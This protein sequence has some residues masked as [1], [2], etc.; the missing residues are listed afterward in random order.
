MG[1]RRNPGRNV[2][3][4]LL[5]DK[6]LGL[7]SN[8]ALQRVKRHYRA[9]KA[10][11]TGSLDPLATGLLPCCLGDSTKFSAFLLDADKRY[12]VRVR[13]GVTTTTADAEGEVVETRPVEGV[14]EERLREVLTRFTGSIDQ[15]PPMYSALKHQGQRLYKL[16]RQGV[17]VERQ[18]RRIDIH[19]LEL[20]AFELPEIELDVHCSKGTYVR[21][22]AEDIGRALGCGGH[23]IALRRTGV[24]PYLESSG[25][26]IALDEVAALAEQEN[27]QA[28]DA[29]LLPLDTALGHCPA[30][31]LSEDSAF[32]LRQ[33]QPV[34]VPQA[35]TEGLVRL[36]DP[37]AR[38]IGVGFILE[39]G[40]V[41]PKRLI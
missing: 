39:D 20:T 17:E 6:P 36:Y 21:T 15:L 18:P 23:V 27:F 13:L 33:G 31:R 29:L 1:R 25:P 32:Y 4:I 19:A 30:L 12:R 5:L 3:G 10:G 16:A 2:T 9:A 22:L 34:L 28:L 11:H 41:Q 26:F 7:T 24:G 37:S 38:F 14:D 8:D 40:K 35:P